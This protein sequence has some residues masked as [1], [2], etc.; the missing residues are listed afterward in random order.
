MVEFVDIALLVLLAGFLTGCNE[1]YEMPEGG[2]EP[3]VLKPSVK[4]QPGEARAGLLT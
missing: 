3:K 1:I 2:G 4:L